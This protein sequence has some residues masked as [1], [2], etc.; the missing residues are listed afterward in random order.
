MYGSRCFHRL[1][2]MV[3]L[4]QFQKHNF[5]IEILLLGRDISIP[6]FL[7]IRTIFTKK[8]STTLVVPC[9]YCFCYVWYFQYQNRT[10][11]FHVFT[12]RKMA[13]LSFYSISFLYTT[14][15]GIATTSSAYSP[16]NRVDLKPTW[17]YAL[18][19]LW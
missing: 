16:T 18:V 15:F 7:V 1:L 3:C 8:I 11:T 17:L 5:D 14:S 9:Q 19:V 13:S 6:L 4:V 2:H 10:K 12:I